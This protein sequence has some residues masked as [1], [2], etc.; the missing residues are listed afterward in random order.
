MEDSMADKQ[1]PG[2]KKIDAG[3]PLGTPGTTKGGAKPAAQPGA[4]TAPANAPKVDKG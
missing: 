2:G 3:G 1:A 4:G